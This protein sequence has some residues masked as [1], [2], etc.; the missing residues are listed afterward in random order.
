MPDAYLL[1][2][3]ICAVDE[4]FSLERTFRKL[5]AYGAAYEYLFVLSRTASEGCRR[6]VK[7]ICRDPRCRS[8]D[9]PGT[10]F[11]DALKTVFREARGTHVVVWSADEATDTASFPE[12][13][14]LS[15]ENPDAVVKIS[16]FLHPDGFAGYGAVK[17]AINA[18]SQRCFGA[19]YGARLTEYTNPTQIAPTALYRR[20]RFERSGFEMTTEMIFK[21][22]RLGVRFFE[23]PTKNVPREEGRSHRTLG[24]AALYYFMILKIRFA[25]PRDLVWPDGG[26]P[27]RGP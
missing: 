11:G 7:G 21:P 19:L 4:T 24:A 25:D 16:R 18:F 14:R 13:L 23:V 2:V 10:G 9:Q 27:Q 8:M 5:D 26:A 22:L 20:I 1:T 3:A 15:R 6:T 17:K 12:M